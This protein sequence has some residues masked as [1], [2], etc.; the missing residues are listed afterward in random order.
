M[1]ILEEKDK[2]AYTEFLQKHD[3]CNFQQSLE[4]AKVKD[5]WENEIVLAED[6]N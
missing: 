4:W 1:R 2:M 5:N 3:R 6:E